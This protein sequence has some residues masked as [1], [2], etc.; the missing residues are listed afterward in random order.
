MSY[1]KHNYLQNIYLGPYL[2][3]V[4]FKT[5]IK[6]EIIYCCTN[7]KCVRYKQ[8][9]IERNNYIHYFCYNC[10]NALKNFEVEEERGLTPFQL[11]A[12]KSEFDDNLSLC[13]DDKIISI[14]ISNKKT[15]WSLR[16]I[17]DERNKIVNSFE[18]NVNEEIDYFKKEFKKEIFFLQEQLG[19]QNI[20]VKHGLIVYL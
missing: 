8:K 10:G 17:N 15:P 12:T 2:Q 16:N 6:K 14:F 9:R 5:I 11:L 3:A 20:E 13:W 4:G 18:V 7:E 1:S 19:Q